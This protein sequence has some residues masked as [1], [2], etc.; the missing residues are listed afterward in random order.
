MG[1]HSCVCLDLAWYELW[2][3]FCLLVGVKVYM[4][5][6]V[7]IYYMLDLFV[8]QFGIETSCCIEY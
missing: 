7:S 6:V 1:G 8:G 2:L 3:L 4:Q 5:L